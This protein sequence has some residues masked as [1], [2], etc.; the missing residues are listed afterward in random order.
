MS[1][2]KFPYNN[3]RLRI[4]ASDASHAPMPLFGS[5]LVCHGANVQE[6]MPVAK[7][8]ELFK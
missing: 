1:E 3:L 2:K 6:K 5:H 8:L 4:L 7:K